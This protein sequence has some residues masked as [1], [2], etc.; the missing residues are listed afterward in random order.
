MPIV[1]ARVIQQVAVIRSWFAGSAGFA[2]G[3]LVKPNV[4]PDQ[5]SVA[6]AIEVTDAMRKAAVQR[7]SQRRFMSSFREA[8]PRRW[9]SGERRLRARR[10]GGLRRSAM[11]VKR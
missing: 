9:G 7:G 1:F 6:P 10:P 4:R 8:V 3:V 5:T 11:V 2:N